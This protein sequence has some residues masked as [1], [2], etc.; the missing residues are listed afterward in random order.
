M[1]YFH[2]LMP[3]TSIVNELN[4]NAYTRGKEQGDNPSVFSLFFSRVS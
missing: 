4:L 2:D 1:G 3:A